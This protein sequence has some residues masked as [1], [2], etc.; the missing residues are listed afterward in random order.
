MVCNLHFLGVFSE[1]CICRTDTGS[2]AKGI[3]FI[4][5]APW[6][7][8]TIGD[9]TVALF[10]DRVVGLR[11]GRQDRLCESAWLRLLRLEDERTSELVDGG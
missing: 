5:I 3:V 11:R 8:E 9:R 2:V 6:L 1:G 10:V 4:Y 7:P